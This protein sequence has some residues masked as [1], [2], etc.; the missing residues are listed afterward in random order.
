MIENDAGAVQITAS[1]LTSLTDFMSPAIICPLKSRK[2]MILPETF[3]SCPTMSYSCPGYIHVHQQQR[4]FNRL[5]NVTIT[6]PVGAV[7]PAKH[8]PY[9][10]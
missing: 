8:S 3:L 10:I 5:R 6:N 2:R 9:F 4:N 7:M 1:G